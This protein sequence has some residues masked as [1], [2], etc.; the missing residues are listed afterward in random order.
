M[1]DTRS[2]S[3]TVNGVRHEVEVETRLTLA[4]CLRHRLRLT[5]THLGCEHGVCGAC[6]VLVDGQAVR[7]CLM[8]AV[9]AE[10]AEVT[11]VEGIAGAG[12]ALHPLQE[13]FR[14]RHGLQ[15]GFCTPGMLMTLM[16]FLDE[17]PA[18]HRGRGARGDLRQSLPLHRVSGHRRGGARCRRT[19]ARRRVGTDVC[20][21][22][23]RDICGHG[24]SSMSSRFMG[25]RPICDG[26][27]IECVPPSP[28]RAR[29][30][31]SQDLPGP[32]TEGSHKWGVHP[33]FIGAWVKRL[34][35]VAVVDSAGPASAEMETNR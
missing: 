10:H 33:R 6:T 17:N 31:R 8:L 29:C 16:E 34:D 2:I 7:S 25:A 22:D 9:Q 12:G 30:P 4:D 11:T 20:G 3:L 35:T 15:C 28:T 21:F 24:G 18:P 26:P 19:L 13:A 14:D 5:G 32:K 27:G 23:R 1:K